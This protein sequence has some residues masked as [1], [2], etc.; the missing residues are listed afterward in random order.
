MRVYNLGE[1][2]SSYLG[3]LGT[4]VEVVLIMYPKHDT[5]RIYE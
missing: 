5:G 3:P 2:S 4:M 1:I